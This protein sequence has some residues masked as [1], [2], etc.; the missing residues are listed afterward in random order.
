MPALDQPLSYIQW[1]RETDTATVPDS[2]LFETYNKYL[3]AWF[4]DKNDATLTFTEFRTNLFVNLLKEIA[5]NYSTNEEKIFLSKVDL[6]NKTEA[7]IV[8]P[9]FVKRLKEI[10]QYLIT[11]RNEVSTK[12]HRQTIKGSELG[13]T[14]DVKQKIISPL[15]DKN[16]V[17]KYPTANIPQLSAISDYIYADIEP[18]IDEY[19]N[20]FDGNLD[21]DISTHIS[22]D[23]AYVDAFKSSTEKI[24]K[25][26]WLDFNTAVAKLI[27]EKAPVVLEVNQ[28][29]TDTAIANTSTY[30]DIELNYPRTDIELL[31]DS[32]FV[33]QIKDQSGLNLNHEKTL[34]EKYA[35]TKMCYLSTGSTVTNT[36]SGVLFDPVNKA[37]NYLNRYNS[38][39]PSVPTITQLKTEKDI[40]KF[41]L[42]H[43]QGVLNFERIT[44]HYTVN[45]SNLQP[46]TCYIFPDPDVYEPGRGSSLSDTSNPFEYTDDNTAVKIGKSNPHAEGNIINDEKV[47]KFYPYQSA[48][49]TIQSQGVGISR[50]TD[51]VDFW[52]GTEKD[53]WADND[54]YTKLPLADFPVNDKQQDLLV[55]DANLEDWKTDIFGNEY[56]LFKT[57]RSTRKSTEQIAG[58]YSKHPVQSSTS[59]ANSVVTGAFDNPDTTFFDYQL[60]GAVTTYESTFNSLT[61]EQT[62][63]DRRNS[64]TPKFYFRNAKSTIISPCSSALSA[65]FI[66]Y[67][68]DTAIKAEIENNIVEIDII[69]D[70]IILQTS[71]Y[72]ILEKFEYDI[73][74]DI[75]TSVLP[76]KVYVS[77]DGLNSSYEKI[78][79]HW[80]DER[81][82]NVY[83][84]KTVLHPFLSGTNHRAIY[85]EIFVYNDTNRTFSKSHSITTLAPIASSPAYVASKPQEAYNLLMSKGFVIGSPYTKS[86]TTSGVDINIVSIDRPI[87]SVNSLEYTLSMNYIGRG[88]DDT[89][90]VFNHYFDVRDSKR[91]EPKQ[92]DV[93][94]PNMN[95]F[96]HNVSQYSDILTLNGLTVSGT[97]QSTKLSRGA[98]ETLPITLEAL[99]GKVSVGDN[100][101]LV[102][103][104]VVYSTN[105]SGRDTN[106]AGVIDSINNIVRLGVGLSASPSDAN[107]EN[108]VEEVG[109]GVH[110][111]SHNI[112]YL[113]TSMA[114]TGLNHDIVVSFDMALYT[115]TSSNSA[116]AQVGTA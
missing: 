84:S 56:A 9:F 87:V 13:I 97:I 22:S 32:E 90:Y 64:S 81:A 25:N 108:S 94:T 37:A 98:P 116:Y 17:A 36:V 45:T 88:P 103:F 59:T 23:K 71:N 95:I 60:S 73:D 35:G 93:F 33:D 18:L 31:P 74:T 1:L 5:L 75:F 101:D 51:D 14:V 8:L 39:H 85:P 80:Y 15:K 6:G 114:L 41:F 66:K 115:D 78:S 49:E 109:T 19:S 96:N 20:Y 91:I 70:I 65:V 21:V 24:D 27:T 46:N 38:G 92:L 113:L 111:Y 110:P 12:K 57:I 62:V 50:W 106:P 76:F 100:E 2:T 52:E 86:S 48:E 104:P 43:K 79:T 61:G 63:S 40:G 26:I 112:S 102:Q 30:V 53:I 10:A 4:S 44:A 68:G 69:E 77:V 28:S 72:T 47:Q 16:F 42:P 54:V 11:K 7:D 3:L 67:T 83:L 34:I 55:D 82:R 107:G 89:P 29:S 99:K 105:L 58:T